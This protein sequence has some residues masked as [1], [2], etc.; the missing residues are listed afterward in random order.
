[1]SV[2]EEAKILELDLSPL[3]LGPTGDF[4]P[5]FCTPDGA[6]IIGSEG[7][8]GIH[9]CFVPGFGEAVFV[10][11]PMALPGQYVQVLARNF[12]DFLQLLLACGHTAALEQASGWDAAQ[13]GAFL[14]ENPVTPEQ[15]VVLDALARA[16]R[17][18][19][20]ERPYEY[21]RAV[22]AE[23]DCTALQPAAEAEDP[24]PDPPWAVTYEGG[25]W[26]GGRG[27]Q[28]Q[29]IKVEKAFD[30][31]GRRCYVPAVYACGQGLVADLC[32]EA[33][34]AQIRAF[35][36][37][38]SGVQYPTRAEQMR[39]EMENPLAWDVRAAAEINGRRAEN[40]H[41]YGLAWLA[42]DCCEEAQ[43]P[44]AARVVE[45]YGLDPARAWSI[46]RLSFP[47][48]TRRRPKLR[49]LRFLL[50][51]EPRPRPG[52]CFC[53]PAAGD[54]VEFILP[55]SGTAHTLTVLD[56]QPETV[57]G[58]PDD[59]FMYPTHCTALTY[60]LM[61]DLPAG[62]CQVRDVLENDAPRQKGVVTAAPSIG[63]IGGTDGPTAVL[64]GSRTVGSAYTACSA[65]HFAP[66]DRVEWE[67]VFR[68]Q[69]YPGC[70]VELL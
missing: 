23:V 3:G 52:P 13:F 67:L 5:Y 46:R 68:E 33:D 38:W 9:Y 58:L 56:S 4:A 42:A 28:G 57:E 24:P 7:V 27:R 60:R 26:G 51:D 1:M 48:A 70:A 11:S 25:F 44:D 31:G 36:E 2:Y 34:P 39:M 54:T 21:L 66:V 65:L 45:H 41:G 61:P 15:R 20:M 53:N 35:A 47:W 69:A 63:I 16:L 64:F 37:R 12:S 49:S 40:Q 59:E 50:E 22:Q 19:A 8:D 43:D 10:V 17:L 18:R 29:E 30:W 6:Q 14:A 55:I 32:M 62:I